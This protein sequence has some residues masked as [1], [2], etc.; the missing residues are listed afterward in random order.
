MKNYY[1]ILGVLPSSSAAEIRASYRQLSKRFHPDVPG[2]NGGFFARINEAYEV[3]SQPKSRKTYDKA[4]RTP[5]SSAAKRSKPS[6]PAGGKAATSAARPAAARSAAVR[7]TEKK[8]TLWKRKAKNIPL[9]MLTRL[10]SIA[11]P[12]SGRFQLQGLIGNIQIAPTTPE[13]L[14]ESTLRKYGSTDPNHLARHAI[15]IRLS[16]ERDLV[17]TL[18]PRP[19]DFGVEFQRSTEEEK[20]TKLRTFLENLLGNGPLGGLFTQQPFG[21]YGAFLPLTLWITVPKG[22]PLFLRDITGSIQVA[23][24]EGEV[25]AKMLGGVMKA[26]NVHGGNLTLNGSSKA[27]LSKATG[28][29]DLMMFGT[30]RI[31]LDGSLSR[32]RAVVDNQAHAEISGQVG[33]LMTEVNEHGFLDIRGTVKDAF[34]DAQDAGRIKLACVESHLKATRSPGARIDVLR[35]KTRIPMAG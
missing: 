30:S 10:M 7:S 14:W 27:F 23:G 17:K 24:V 1:A 25:V 3:L 6:S 9:P 22:T 13:N 29:I 33:Q 32:M 15:Q 34:C 28:N 2:G 21:L 26:R 16:G 12:R 20:K 31:Y 35:R 4:W 5:G 19:T 8:S 11:V 18:L